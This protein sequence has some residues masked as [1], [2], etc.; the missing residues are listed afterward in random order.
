MELQTRWTDF[1][2]QLDRELNELRDELAQT[3]LTRARVSIEAICERLTREVT[4]DQAK[5]MLDEPGKVL[6][7]G[8][9][10]HGTVYT[11]VFDCL[12]ASKYLTSTQADDLRYVFGEAVD[13]L[14]DGTT[15]YKQAESA[16]KMRNAIN[17]YLSE[18]G[19]AVT[20]RNAGLESAAVDSLSVPPNAD[21][22]TVKL[23]EL[24]RNAPDREAGVPITEL[25]E[26]LHDSDLMTMM[27]DADLIEFVR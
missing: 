11:G 14:R 2:S 8:W 7:P 15:P 19:Y 5:R 12:A 9:K 6:L 20:T 24:L 22:R 18:R 23:L 10:E 26:A 21:P 3:D 1:L 13:F 17:R 4:T 16:Q 25:P 27:V